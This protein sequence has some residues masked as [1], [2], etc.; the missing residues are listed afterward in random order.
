MPLN[1]KYSAY[2]D[3]PSGMSQAA[4]NYIQSLHLAGVPVTTENIAN[5]VATQDLGETHRT[6]HLLLGRDLDYKIKIIH[7]T[8]DL[9]TK[10][11]EPLKYHIFHLFWETDRLPDWWVWSLNLVDEIWTGSEYAKQVFIKSGVKRP[12]FVFPQAVDTPPESLA[13]APSHKRPSFLFYSIFQWIERK[14]PKSLLMA[15]WKEFQGNKD[16]GLLIKTYK[17]GFT[18]EETSQIMREILAWKKSLHQEHYPKVFLCPEELSRDDVWR[19]HSLGDCFVSAH[20]NEGWGIPIAEALKMGKPVIST[21]LG[22]VHEF[23]PKDAALLTDFTMCNVFNMDFV[24][25]YDQTQQWAQVDEGDLRKKM[26]AVYDNQ[27][28]SKKMGERGRKFANDKLSYLAVG[29]ALKSRIADIY[30]ELEKD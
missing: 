26:R 3:S 15:Y 24:S 9:V 30:K 16:V 27:E 5:I 21:N 13:I 22:G 14:N 10:Y 11:L 18:Q 6:A 28:D 20:R 25:W 19:L 23:I 7:V 8:P 12:I 4:R 17:N 29:S 2:F 1:V